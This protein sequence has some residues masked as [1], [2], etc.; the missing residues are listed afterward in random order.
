MRKIISLLAAA[1]ILP[2]LLISPAYGQVRDYSNAKV[3]S[4]RRAA[5]SE[6][7]SDKPAVVIEVAGAPH[8]IGGLYICLQ[9]GQLQ[10]I[11]EGG[12]RSGQP[13]GISFVVPMRDWKRLKGGE[14]MWLSWGCL[15]PSTYERMKPFAYLDKKMLRKK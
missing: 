6:R 12:L 5:K 4:I 14:P 3:K 11:P 9:I 15:Q 7:L 13:V 8:Y 10:G 2:P 1:I